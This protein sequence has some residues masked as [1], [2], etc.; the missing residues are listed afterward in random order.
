MIR[1]IFFNIVLILIFLLSI[2]IFKLST[3]GVETKRFNELISNTIDKKKNIQLE[4]KSIFFKLDPK[5]LSLFLETKNPIINYETLS[6][7]IQNAK[8]YIDFLSVNRLKIKKIDLN[9]DELDIFEIN[10]LSKFIKPSNFKN[11]N[12]KINK[13]K[14]IS[15]VEIFL[16][17]RY[18]W[19]F[20]I[21]GDIKNFEANIITLYQRLDLTF[22]LIMKIY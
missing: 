2:I 15:E 16:I 20:I 10:K 3:T 14:L 6:I 19:D 9:L 1:K 5:E 7:P 22:L 21:K 12:N 4:L 11:F 8:V 13:G 18:G 17:T